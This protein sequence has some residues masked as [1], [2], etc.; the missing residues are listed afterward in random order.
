MIF[1]YFLAL[2]RSGFSII[3]KLV[4]YAIKYIL[5]FLF[6]FPLHVSLG[7]KQKFLSL[8]NKFWNN[9][10]CILKEEREMICSPRS[11]FSSL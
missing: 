9:F 10:P 3:K 1:L 4:F 2:K 7:Y 8:L 5:Q 11:N 6:L